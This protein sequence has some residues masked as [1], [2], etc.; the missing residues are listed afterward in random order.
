M[1]NT[2]LVISSDGSTRSNLSRILRRV[3]LGSIFEECCLK[4]NPK[5]TK[6]KKFDIIVIDAKNLDNNGMIDTLQSQ[7]NDETVLVVLCSK[8]P[9]NKDARALYMIKPATP[10]KF[11]EVLGIT[12]QSSH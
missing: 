10:D 4:N 11:R 2:A 3:G 7:P 8:V 12:G 6:V 5:I 9:E 1:A